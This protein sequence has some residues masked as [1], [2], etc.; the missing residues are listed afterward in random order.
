MENFKDFYKKETTSIG[1][2]SYRFGNFGGRKMSNIEIKNMINFIQNNNNNKLII[3]DIGAG[4]GRLSKKLA[5][6]NYEVT[7]LDSSRKMISQIPHMK[8]LEKKV[9]SLF[10]L[11]KIFRKKKFDVFVSLR[12]FF[13][14][15]KHEKLKALKEI[16]KISNKHSL[17]LIDTLNKKS[18]DRFLP[19]LF[20]KHKE[21][22]YY[23][24]E[25][26]IKEIIK[27]LGGKEKLKRDFII[28]RGIYLHA[29]GFLFYPIRL[30]D[31]L[32]LLTPFKYFASSFTWAINF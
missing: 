14:L 6:M 9:G 11:S 12:V 13:H 29:P 23:E 20:S 24:N 21:L 27:E 10:D 28:P 8:N 15:S 26:E 22:N 18:L 25:R 32:L 2:D 5:M 3:L 31:K 19:N 30:I 17:I 4:T 1:Y 16:K 7:S